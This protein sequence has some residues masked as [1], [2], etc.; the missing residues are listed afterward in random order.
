M[1]ILIIA[2]MIIIIIVFNFCLLFKM[3][4]KINHGHGT[5][6]QGNLPNYAR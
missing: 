3:F 5:E 4:N 2:I 1:F 6:Q